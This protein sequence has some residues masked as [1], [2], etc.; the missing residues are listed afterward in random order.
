MGVFTYPALW[1]IQVHPPYKSL[2]K[3]S[4]QYET[5]QWGGKAAPRLAVCLPTMHCGLWGTLGGVGEVL[6]LQHTTTSDPP[7]APAKRATYKHVH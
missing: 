3:H 1:R 7:M 2:L 5:S 4:Q 6:F